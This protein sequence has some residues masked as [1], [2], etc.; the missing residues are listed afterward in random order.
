MSNITETLS[1]EPTLDPI[2]ISESETPKTNNPAQ[3]KADW[4]LS[5]FHSS[6][7][8]LKKEGS[9]KE[10]DTG[11]WKNTQNIYWNCSLPNKNKLNDKIYERH[12]VTV[13]KIVFLA[14]QGPL[15][16]GNGGSEKA[17]SGKGS[18]TCIDIR[19]KFTWVQRDRSCGNTV[20]VQNQGL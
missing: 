3:W 7:W 8:I 15:L 17:L 13:K 6:K 1:E 19:V 16:S 12:L 20:Y 18:T 9:Y 14:R 5:K 4:L 2:A 11:E 10:P